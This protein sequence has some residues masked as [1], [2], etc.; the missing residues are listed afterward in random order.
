MIKPGERAELRALARPGWREPPLSSA[1]S[2]VVSPAKT[3][4]LFGR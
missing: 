3:P 2:D 4:G 1:S